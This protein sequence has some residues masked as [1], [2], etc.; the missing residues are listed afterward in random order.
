MK[1]MKRQ[2][3]IMAS[4]Y[5]KIADENLAA[6]F[7]SMSSRRVEESLG[8]TLEGD[9]LLFR[10]FGA[11]CT[12]SPEGIELGGQKLTD[13][14]ALLISLYAAHA[15]PEPFELEPF[16]A[17]KDLPGSMPYQ[18]AFS[19]NSERVLVPHV[20]AIRENAE[21]IKAAFGSHEVTEDIGGDFLFVLQALPKIALCYIFYLP[22]EEFPASAT[23]LFSSNALSFMPLDGLADVA[24]YTS[25]E[26]L[27]LI[28]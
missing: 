15:A 14:R 27:R 18:G 13:P 21:T 28:G 3:K 24:E 17:F 12:L 5:E 4:N 6:F 2:G 23:C 8:A 11:A 26:I 20:P 1:K 16:R 22:D 9:A 25:R 19:A 10:A 7:S